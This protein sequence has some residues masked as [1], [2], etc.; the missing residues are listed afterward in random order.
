[1]KDAST[2]LCQSHLLMP[3]LRL[4]TTQFSLKSFHCTLGDGCTLIHGP[5]EG[6]DRP[7]R[8]FLVPTPR[9]SSA[10]FGYLALS[11]FDVPTSKPSRIP[12]IKNTFFI[13]FSILIF[14]HLRPC[15]NA[16]IETSGVMGRQILL[17]CPLFGVSA[18]FSQCLHSR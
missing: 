10:N 7:L 6:G 11:E 17:R 2:E 14:L 15:V 1:M 4:L 18:I 5:K 12:E 16:I 3:I 8:S 13:V 9:C